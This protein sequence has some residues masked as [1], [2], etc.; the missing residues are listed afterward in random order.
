MPPKEAAKAKAKADPKKKAAKA[1]DD[2]PK[3]DKPD[4]SAKDTKLAEIQAD[5]DR[6][7]NDQKALTQRINERSGGKDEFFE[8]R[9]KIRAKL[10]EYSGEMNKLQAKKDEISKVVDQKR[11]ENQE[12]KSN[13][14]KLKK[15]VGFQSETEIDERIASIE[16]KLWTE[17]ITL[18][19]EKKLLLEIQDLKRNRPK[20]NQI[21]QMDASIQERFDTTINTRETM[22]SINEEMKK[23]HELKKGVHQ[24]LTDLQKQRDDKLGDMPN[25][26]KERDEIHKQV[27][28]KI[29]MRND[30]REE[31]K[32]KERDYNA[33]IQDLRRKRQQ[34]YEE[35][36]AKKQAEY[37][38]K[39]LEREAEKLNDQPHLEEMTLIEQTILFCKNLTVDDKKETKETT[40]EIVHNNPE[41]TEILMR[42]EDRAEEYY[43]APTA[44]KKS[45]GK[46]GSGGE[47]SGAKPIKHN[48]NTFQLFDKLNVAPP[49]TTDDVPAAL[50]KL[51]EQLEM[52][53][54]KVSEWEEQRE[55]QKRKILELGILPGE[56][57]NEE[58]EAEPEEK[59]EEAVAEEKPAEEEEE[60]EK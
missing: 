2:G 37:K 13:L 17:S 5:I 47:K 42:K 1:E 16:F 39:R 15:S 36:R 14:S 30:I 6:L 46:K 35:E 4:S 18:K 10:D 33:H 22:K 48:A 55:E 19:E 29:K 3:M 40:R 54:G 43:Y 52:Y 12:M 24:Q 32:Q 60:E 50:E 34:K 31:F 11:L 45:K 56:N 44:K 41:N 53:R 8:Q 58:E 28:E 7:N 49:I 38:Q 27:Q 51:Q 23:Y 21:A 57:E 25:L 59:K 20:V 9:T 26:I